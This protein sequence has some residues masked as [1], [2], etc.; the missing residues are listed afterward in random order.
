MSRPTPRSEAGSAAGTAA[1]TC[2]PLDVEQVH[3]EG[4]LAVLEVTSQY[5][6]VTS[7]IATALKF[8]LQPVKLVTPMGTIYALYRT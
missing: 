3:G 7:P 2:R 4:E 6:P 8:I 5:R 1:P